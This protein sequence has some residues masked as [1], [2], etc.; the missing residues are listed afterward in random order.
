ME[1]KT[2][3]IAAAIIIVL[4][5]SVYA[6]STGLISFGSRTYS[7]STLGVSFKY[8]T[9]YVLEERAIDSAHTAV[10]LIQ[11]E[12][13]PVPQNGEGP[14]AI[15]VDVFRYLGSMGAENWVRTSANSNFQLAVD[16]ELEVAE[17][18]GAEVVTYTWDGLY[19]GD[20]LVFV[21]GD[22]IVMFSVTYL[23][24]EDVI[25]TDFSDLIST[26]KLTVPEN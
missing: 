26:V 4:G 7:N 19:R 13:L 12:N 21:H 23:T 9:A 14:T 11:K 25:R 18:D 20:S 5:A 16:G 3:L 17:L 1:K 8:P 2:I 6:F 22:S 10:T 24:P 15:T